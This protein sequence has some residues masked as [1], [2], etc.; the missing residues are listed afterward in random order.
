MKLVINTRKQVLRNCHYI[1]PLVPPVVYGKKWEDG[2]TDKMANDMNYWAFEPGA[3]W[4]GFEGY[5]KGQYFIDADEAAVR[6][7]RH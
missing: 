2:D 5:A 4:H 3:K 7:G 6:Y 1:R